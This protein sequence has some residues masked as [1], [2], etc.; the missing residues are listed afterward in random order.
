MEGIFQYSTTF[1]H[2]MQPEEGVDGREML[3]R[4]RGDHAIYSTCE[5]KNYLLYF[6]KL[7]NS[8]YL[9]YSIT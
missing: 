1:G 4:A 7:S 9:L 6:H 8:D 2:K 3:G 5:A